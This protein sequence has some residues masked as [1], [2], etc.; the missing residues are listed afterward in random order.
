MRR[1]VDILAFSP[2]PDD[3]ELGSAGSLILSARK[4]VR[5][6][7]ADVSN[8]ECASRGTS[9]SR[10][11][12]K[13]IA[14]EMMGISARFSLGLPDTKIGMES[15]HRLAI[16]QLIRETKPRTVLA[17]YWRDRHPDHSATGR[18]VREAAF[19]AGV[20]SIGEGAP[21]R[22]ERIFYYMIHRP[23]QPSFVINISNVWK[24][25][26]RVLKSYRSQFDPNGKGFKTA[27]ARSEF[28]PLIE[29]RSLW[30][31]AMIGAMYGEPFLVSGP[32]P[33]LQFPGLELP[34][35]PKGSL[36]PYSMFN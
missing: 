35:P 7:I 16:V 17:P 12:E 3:A 29:A 20:A 24:E 34:P 31:G 4:G 18:L 19:Y 10:E 32:V 27:L 23:F 21:H 9:K 30:F 15:S 22:P 33:L 8:G 25:K 13:R 11:K 5:T 2:H 14:S 36:P 1:S 26:I 6:A 28:L